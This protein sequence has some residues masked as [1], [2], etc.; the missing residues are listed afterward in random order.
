M[1]Q[2]SPRTRAAGI[3]RNGG[4]AS[5]TVGAANAQKNPPT[6]VAGFRR[7]RETAWPVSRPMELITCARPWWHPRSEEHTS[8][9]QSLLRISYAGFGLKKKPTI[10]D[11][12]D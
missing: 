10:S 6:C 3:R 12:P 9:L 7:G 11:Q 4:V 1:G 8:E 5:A 2:P